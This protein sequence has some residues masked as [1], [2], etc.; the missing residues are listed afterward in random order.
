[1]PTTIS[2]IGKRIALAR[3]KAGLTQASLAEMIE[4]SEKYLSR[5]E[6]GKQSPNAII[7]VKICESLRISADELLFTGSFETH[8]MLDAN[9]QSVMENFSPNDKDHI[10]FILQAIK[11]IKNNY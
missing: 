2:T 5:V 7:I 9:I 8:N 6:C 11:A 10:F 4:I 3:K 1:M